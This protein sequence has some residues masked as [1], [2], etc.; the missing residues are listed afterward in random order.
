MNYYLDHDVRSNLYYI[1]PYKQTPT[2]YLI[3]FN[4]RYLAD[5]F[6]RKINAG[7]ILPPSKN[8]K[9]YC[10]NERYQELRLGLKVLEIYDYLGT[11]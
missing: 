10:L 5:Q 7:L 4:K 9:E 3:V 11:L 2:P 8:E 6:L 1:A